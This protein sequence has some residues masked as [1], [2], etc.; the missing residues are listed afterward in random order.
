MRAKMTPFD[1]VDPITLCS[2][3]KIGTNLGNILYQQAIYKHLS[4]PNHIITINNNSTN[5]SKIDFIN[6]NYDVFVLPLAN[7]FRPSFINNL[8]K[9][10]AFIKALKIPVVVIGIGAQTDLHYNF[11]NLSPIKA[12]VQDFVKAVLEKSATIGVRGEATQAYLLSLGF[13]DVDVIGCPS[14]FTYANKFKINKSKDFNLDSSIALNLSAPGKQAAFSNNL[15]KFSKIFEYNFYRYVNSTYIPQETRSLE[16]LIYGDN[17]NK[18]NEHQILSKKI[19]DDMFSQGKVKFFV[20]ST[21]WF[22]FLSTKNLVFGT[23]LHGCIAGL[24]GG[25]PSVLLAHDSRTLEI[26]QYF[27]IPHKVLNDMPEIIDAEQLFNF[28]DEKPMLE[29]YSENLKNYTDF[30]ERNGLDHILYNNDEMNRFDENIQAVNHRKEVNV[31]DAEPYAIGQR[32]RWI[33][34]SYDLKLSKLQKK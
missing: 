20:N 24:L 3:D 2:Y 7:A 27:K 30:L 33:Q 17:Q 31:L 8:K 12:A 29:K 6:E 25:T 19:S 28:F 13:K 18:G 23:R 4:T 14:M 26:A 21:T 16:Y 9:L 15:H 10:T 11:D 32:L 1:N 34:E 5:V 22:N